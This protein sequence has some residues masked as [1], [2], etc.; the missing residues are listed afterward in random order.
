MPRLDN[1]KPLGSSFSRIRV[2]PMLEESLESCSLL[3]SFV[4][5]DQ[6]YK[7]A[8]LPCQHTSY[9]PDICLPLA[10]RDS[11]LISPTPVGYYISR[12]ILQC[13]SSVA[14]LDLRRI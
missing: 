12:M 10:V 9:R 11:L 5:G 2:E 1:I 6:P 7:T 13:L 4:I 3:I 14:Y 8:Y